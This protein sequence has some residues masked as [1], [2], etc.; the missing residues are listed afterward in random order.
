MK[1][2]TARDQLYPFIIKLQHAYIALLSGS[3]VSPSIL[4]PN[5]PMLLS[6]S[7]ET[8][9]G[10]VNTLKDQYQRMLQSS[11]SPVTS[12]FP[13]QGEQDVFNTNN[14][15]FLATT[16]ATKSLQAPSAPPKPAPLP[17]SQPR[18]L[19]KPYKPFH[20]SQAKERN[21]PSSSCTDSF[22]CGKL[23]SV[24][25]SVV[26]SE[27]TVRCTTCSFRFHHSPQE[28][29]AEKFVTSDR[30]LVELEI[31]PILESHRFRKPNSIIS[32]GCKV[33]GG[34]SSYN[35][36]QLLSHLENHDFAQLIGVFK[37]NL[38]RVIE[39]ERIRD[40]EAQRE[41]HNE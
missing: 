9:S 19:Y 40:F 41:L 3:S 20:E 28:N 29:K 25:G 24:M 1:I 36:D 37:E 13:F 6:T 18:Q 22:C 16:N 4:L 17:P 2:E 39:V 33:C 32:Y 23:E 31:T 8:R 34:F 5:L 38:D 27:F 30:L 12:N 7:E 21:T 10:V 15:Y 35:W 11:V 14:P 26:G